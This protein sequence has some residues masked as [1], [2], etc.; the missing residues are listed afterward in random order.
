[1][2]TTKTW[3]FII[4][5]SGPSG[6][7]L[8][9]KLAVTPSKPL[10]LLLE[11]GPPADDIS[12]RV[13][14]QRWATHQREGTNWGYKTT[15]QEHCNNRQVDY[16]RGRILGGSSAIN[17]GVYTIGARDDYEVWSELVDDKNFSW[18][19]MQ[20]RYKAL[21]NFDFT[22]KNP[23]HRHFAGPK[24]E[25]HGKEGPLK[26]GFAREWEQ[27]LP[28]VMEVFQEAGVRWNPDHNSGDPLGVS[29]AINSV[30]EGLRSTAKDLLDD[31]FAKGAG[32]NLEIRTG[33][34]VRRVL[35]E[36][37]G[38]KAVGV[39]TLDGEVYRAS[40]EIILS[41]GS[42]DTPKI[43]MHS[44]LGPADQL[45]KFN[46]P[47]VKDIPAIGQNLQDHALAPV[48]FL[49]S[50]STN[51]RNAFFGDESAKAAAL[52]QWHKDKTGPWTL[53]NAQLMVGWLKSD[54]ISASKEFANLPEEAKDILNR[55]TIPHYEICS[56]FPIHEIVPEWG[57]EFSYLCFLAFL[58][59][60]QSR[61]EVT[62]QSSDPS[63]PLLFNP[64]FLAHEY[65][66]RVSIEVMRELLAVTEREAFKKDTVA[67]ML[68]PNSNSDEDI[69]EHWKNVVGS[70][71]HMTGTV[72]MGKKEDKDAVVDTKFGFRGVQGLR[73]ADMS[74]LPRLTTGHTQAAAYVTGI[75]AAD[76]LIGKYGLD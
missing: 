26:L 70:S 6:S 31:A 69:L 7:A 39:E 12:L 75:T 62:L 41:A 65:D 18:E 49:R 36:N 24:E 64:N 28:P 3:D 63:V 19:P 25:D 47:V 51:T 40:K 43:L 74:V 76:V 73:I 37:D 14:G 16:S 15:P 27:D 71:W 2:S 20:A 33:K 45:T 67:L 52:E 17:F 66:R 50:P 58:M 55:P 38:R 54:T 42:L 10:I 11:A 4:V 30:H 23:E 53:H 21:E 1:M 32:G 5:G 56:H 35:L 72:K 60:G 61:G 48:M 29:L 57:T 34:T 59:N 44:G 68:G 46:I 8:A 9:S 22:I 13:D